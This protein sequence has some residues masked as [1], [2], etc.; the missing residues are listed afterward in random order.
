MK[1]SETGNNASSGGS[2]AGRSVG[3]GSAH[4]GRGNGL[5]KAS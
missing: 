2:D 3:K 5:A 1:A 4:F